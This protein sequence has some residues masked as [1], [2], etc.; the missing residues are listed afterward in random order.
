MPP[1]SLLAEAVDAGMTV[2]TDDANLALR[3]PRK[4]APLARILLERKADLLPL[5]R[6]KVEPP[7]AGWLDWTARTIEKVLG[8]PPGSTCLLDPQPAGESRR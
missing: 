2:A 1:E 3:G 7:D 8:L 4:M 5:L 6:L